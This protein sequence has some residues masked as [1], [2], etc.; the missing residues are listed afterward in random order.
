MKSGLDR[1]LSA[2]D[3]APAAL[4][5]FLRDDDAGW[6]D[7]TLF[8]LLD[9]TQRAGVPVDLAVIPQAASAA[10]ATSLCRRASEAPAMYCMHNK[11]ELRSGSRA[12]EKT[13]TM[14][15]CSSDAMVRASSPKSGEILS[16]T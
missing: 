8:G 12:S 9:H 3:A 11:R 4:P 16:A 6:A 5:F 10:L 2:L 14:F 13:L 7:D 15:W 1:L